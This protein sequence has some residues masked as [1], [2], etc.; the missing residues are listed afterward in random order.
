MKC[1]LGLLHHQGQVTLD[2]EAVTRQNIAR[3]SFATC[4]H[5]FFPALTPA[6]HRDF[7]R[8]QFPRFRE[9]RL[10]GSDGIFSGCPWTGPSGAT[11]PGRKTSLR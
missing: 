4:E 10:R 2:G 1:V 3:L 11:P 6:D 7:Y 9:K 8:S 5:S